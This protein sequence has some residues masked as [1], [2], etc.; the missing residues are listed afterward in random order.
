MIERVRQLNADS[1]AHKVD[2]LEVLVIPSDIFAGQS[3]T[4]AGAAAFVDAKK[5]DGADF[6]K[7][8]A[9]S[10]DAVLGLFQ[11]S[12]NQN[13]EVSGHLSPTVSALDSSNAGMRAMSTSAPAGA[14]S[15]TAL[16]IKIASET[17]RCRCRQRCSRW[18]PTT[19]STR[20]YTTLR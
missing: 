19:S 9:G 2:A 14:S 5:A 20:G 15:S 1:A 12:K 18:R 11:E 7:M 4:A 6:I 16:R 8:T 13:L 3:A 17:Q 10:R